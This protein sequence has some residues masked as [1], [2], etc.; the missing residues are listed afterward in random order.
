M[1]VYYGFVTPGKMNWEVHVV[2]MDSERRN[3]AL[4]I[5]SSSIPLNPHYDAC[6][7]SLDG[8][9][10]GYPGSG[11][12]QLAFAMLVNAYYGIE[13]D[14][15]K[16]AMRWYQHFK[17]AVIEKLDKDK[18][19]HM[20]EYI[21]RAVMSTLINIDRR[22]RQTAVKRKGIETRA[23]PNMPEMTKEEE[24]FHRRAG[25][26]VDEKSDPTATIPLDTPKDEPLE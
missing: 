1:K 9:G 20:D 25:T 3:L 22:R 10:W 11:P 14:P 15:I 6:K 17:T 4:Q 24:E 23:W 8:F 12:A 7:H 18:G 16:F 19:F 26:I 21:V 2:E 5:S 13:P